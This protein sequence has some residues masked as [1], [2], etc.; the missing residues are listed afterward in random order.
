MN[1]TRRESLSLV[2]AALILPNCSGSAKR[3]IRVGSKNFAENVT[4]AEIYA[5][6]LQQCGVPVERRVDLGD[7]KTVA[8]ALSRG[9][10]DLYP[11]YTGTGLMVVLGMQNNTRDVYRT[12]KAKYEDMHP[13]LTWLS[14]SPMNNS[15]A[16][17]MTPAAA[18]QYG[19]RTLSDCASGANQ[20]RL[21]AV[22]DFSTRSDSLPGLQRYYGGFQFKELLVAEEIGS[23]YD[24]ILHQDAEVAE[25]FTTDP[26]LQTGRFV[27]L[28]D[29]RR[30][31]PPYN[32]APVIRDEVNR[33]RPLAAAVL[34]RISPFLNQ[35]VARDLNYQVSVEKVDPQE[36]AATFLGFC[37]KLCDDLRP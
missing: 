17:V 2:G 26:Q 29:D 10:I 6:A 15:Q 16:L 19:I 35:T 12:V 22:G 4:I 14:P 32:V 20:L 28:E 11:E 24:A 30:F 36:A 31:W 5:A 37:A 9:E 27:Q 34:N 23:Q 18:K 8:D 25:A 1:L 7:T 33:A 21:S 13:P 3:P